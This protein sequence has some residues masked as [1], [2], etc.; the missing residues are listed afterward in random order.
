[1]IGQ[2]FD[3][4]AASSNKGG[5]INPLKTNCWKLFWVTLNRKRRR[6]K[7]ADSV[8]YVNTMQLN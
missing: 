7:Q 8:L 5:Y 2:F 6:H 4:I 3:T 1:M